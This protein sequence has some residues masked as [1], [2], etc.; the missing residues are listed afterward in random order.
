[1]SVT[2]GI[3]SS[4]IPFLAVSFIILSLLLVYSFMEG[5][6]TISWGTVSRKKV[7]NILHKLTFW[8]YHLAFMT[9]Y[10]AT[11]VKGNNSD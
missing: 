8:L 7:N 9:M 6:S 10:F 2:L 5:G 11:L 3:R 4:P 1:M